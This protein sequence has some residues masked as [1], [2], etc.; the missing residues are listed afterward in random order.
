MELKELAE[1]MAKWNED[2]NMTADKAIEQ[3]LI[4]IGVKQ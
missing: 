2:N 4:G 1:L 3:I